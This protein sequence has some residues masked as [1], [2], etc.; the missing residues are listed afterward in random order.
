[1]YYIIVFKTN[2]EIECIII[3]FIAKYCRICDD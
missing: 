2:T 1:M 3:E